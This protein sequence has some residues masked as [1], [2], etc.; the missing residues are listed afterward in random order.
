MSVLLLNI[1]IVL[2]L[3][4]KLEPPDS[5]GERVRRHGVPDCMH[6]GGDVLRVIRADV[7]SVG[8]ASREA[9]EVLADRGPQR[10]KRGRGRRHERWDGGDGFAA[11]RVGVGA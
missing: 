6:L 8:D 2:N 7:Q 9:M 5:P 3:L 10:G 11:S 4:F 1:V